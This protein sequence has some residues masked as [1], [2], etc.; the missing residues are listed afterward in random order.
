MFPPYLEMWPHLS[1]CLSVNNPWSPLAD[2]FSSLLALYILDVFNLFSEFTQSR[3]PL[4]LSGFQAYFRNIL[5]SVTFTSNSGEESGPERSHQWHGSTKVNTWNIW[6]NICQQVCS[7]EMPKMG[8]SRE[9]RPGNVG[10]CQ[11][12]GLWVFY[13]FSM[14]C[15]EEFN[16]V[17][18]K[19]MKILILETQL[20][21]WKTVE[22]GLR[23]Q[24]S[25][26]GRMGK[27]VI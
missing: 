9:L 4:T 10:R 24:S 13:L 22:R 17:T 16:A 11:I 5:M 21:A 19:F 2:Y 14:R 3:L 25:K 12:K 8:Q 7:L 23:R 20:V 18:K 1:C 15:T 26:V 27:E 6:E